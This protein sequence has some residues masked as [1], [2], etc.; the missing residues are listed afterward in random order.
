MKNKPKISRRS[1]VKASTAL[2]GGAYL[3]SPMMANAHFFQRN[4]DS[5]QLAWL[6][7]TAPKYNQGFTWGTC[8]P[9]GKVKRESSFDLV[10]SEREEIPVQSWP[11]AY[12][13]D[14]S[15]KWTGHA[16]PAIELSHTAFQLSPTSKAKSLQGMKVEE[17]DTT[18]KIDTGDLLYTIPKS[19]NQIISSIQKGERSLAKNGRLV[20]LHQNVSDEDAADQ[21]MKTNFQGNISKISLEQK[22]ALRS[23][24][25]IEGS[26]R[27]DSGRD[28]I[29][30]VVRLYFYHQAAS[31]KM[32]HTIIF[33]GE[34]ETD[35]IKG[36]GVKFDV[37]MKDELHDRH[38]RFAGQDDGIFSEAVR[39]LTGLR[40]DPGKVIIGAQ[41]AGEKTPAISEF[42]ANV[43]KNIN[44]IPAF[45]DYTLF[46]GDADS[47][48]IRKRTAEGHSWLNSAHGKRARGLVAVGGPSGSFAF[49]VRNFWESFPGQL[50]IKNAH[51]DTAEVTA[52]LWAPNSPA[53]DLRFY[54]DGMGQDTYPKQLDALDITYEDYEPGFGT[55]KGVARTSEL[56]FWTLDATPSHSQFNDMCT[57]LEEPPLLTA[58]SEYM[59]QVGVFGGLWYTDKL[60][61]DRAKEFNE[62][63]DWYFDFYQKQ[64]KEHKWYGFWDFGDFMHTYDTDRHMWRYDVGGFAWDNSE[65]STDLWLWYYY[66]KTGKKEAFRVAEAMT[67][68]TGEVDV[69][70]SGPFAPLG[71]RHNVM[72]WG[73]SAKQ[74]RIST[75]ANRRFFYYLT[76]D[77]RT[78]DLMR[79]QVNAAEALLKVVPIRKVAPK[80][81]WGTDDPN[82]VY[83]GFGT[84]WGSVAAAW[85][86]EWERTEDKEIR[87]KLLNSM[88][89]IGNQPKGFY[90]MGSRM[91]LQT[92]EFE[93]VK[94]NRASA[95][96]LSAVFGLTEI[97]IELY[98]L[99]DM[100]S[101][102]KAW[103]QYCE[104]Y[105]ASPEEQENVLGNRLGKLNLQQGHARLTAF[106]AKEK[107]D[108]RLAKRAWEEF[109]AGEGGIRRHGVAKEISGPEVLTPRTEALGVSTNAT[110]QWGL[111]AMHCLA[112]LGEK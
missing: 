103:L 1:F 5:V 80:E 22:G 47:F 56:N 25:K 102:N 95:S 91:N 57:Y 84:D 89:S 72:H 54:H 15:L 76:A 12:W 104:M 6:G 10:S 73:C 26:H 28:F 83:L 40:R 13:P 85:L 23:V 45:G 82:R 33:D 109:Y 78:G 24:V 71:S 108:P 81:T 21:I 94:T 58:D 32:V 8:W 66:L 99:V 105:N 19:G 77:E 34:E 88:R 55:A 98:E 64:V 97:A 38:I 60:Q 48:S 7:N 31:F 90:S 107:S 43:S 106:V 14:G 63:L 96:H 17:S 29:S 35:F 70:H 39:G 67:R 93:K 16:V 101:F 52:W 111:A 36:I 42:P 11:L 59:L 110:A 41:L 9:K 30:Y 44:Y 61:S 20:V 46:Q 53:M 18:I 49:G 74:L 112:I 69:H 68:H 50:D 3:L 75:A 37:P 79:E 51:T 4:N 100:K 2:T 86:T 65:L 27:S 62:Q 87:E 92:G